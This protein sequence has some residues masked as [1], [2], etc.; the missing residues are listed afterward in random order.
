MKTQYRYTQMQAQ[1]KKQKKQEYGHWRLNKLRKAWTEKYIVQYTTGWFESCLSFSEASQKSTL[2]QG[3]MFA[4]KAPYPSTV[5]RWLGNQQLEYM[6]PFRLGLANDNR[7]LDW[8][9]P[10]NHF[11]PIKRI[12]EARKKAS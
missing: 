3:G 12:R 9:D 8:I 7:C 4:L 10:M 6:L 2:D 1:N 5:P 11:D